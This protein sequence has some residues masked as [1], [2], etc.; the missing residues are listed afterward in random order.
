MQARKRGCPALLACSAA[1][2]LEEGGR[3]G[4]GRHGG[5]ARLEGTGPPGQGRGATA[6]AWDSLETQQ[7]WWVTARGAEAWDA[8]CPGRK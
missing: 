2:T 3:T 1:G 7:Y 4:R 6:G 8:R 5:R